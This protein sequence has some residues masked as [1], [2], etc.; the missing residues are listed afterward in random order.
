MHKWWST[1]PEYAR[2]I[3]IT[4]LVGAVGWLITLGIP[5]MQNWLAQ[6]IIWK[7]NKIRDGLE[8][9][10]AIYDEPQTRRDEKAYVSPDEIIEKSHYPPW[11]VRWAVR[12]QERQ[13]L[14]NEKPP[15]SL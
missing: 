6:R 10:H 12:W 1:L 7:L 5:A 3:I 9:W 13:L 2:A 8:L 11:L 14:K 4:A 15:F